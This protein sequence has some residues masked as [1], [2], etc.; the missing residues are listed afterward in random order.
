MGESCRQLNDL[1]DGTGVVLQGFLERIHQFSQ[2]TGFFPIG[3]AILHIASHASGLEQAACFQ[4]PETLAGDGWGQRKRF[5]K[6]QHSLG[7]LAEEFGEKTEAPH[8]GQHA[9]GAPKGGAKWLRVHFHT[10]QSVEVS[11]QPKDSVP[12]SFAPFCRSSVVL[13]GAAVAPL[14]LVARPP[15]SLP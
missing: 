11:V 5:S 1:F 14:P 6:L 4:S 3:N 15:S 13:T 2:R 10:L 7:L 12:R 9:G 8:V